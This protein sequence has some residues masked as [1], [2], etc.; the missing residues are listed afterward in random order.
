MSSA[1]LNWLVQRFVRNGRDKGN[2]FSATDA[3]E[4]LGKGMAEY[5]THV[6]TVCWISKPEGDEDFIMKGFKY[7]SEY[8]EASLMGGRARADAQYGDMAR[9]R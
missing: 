7:T 6:R 9:D 2:S 4:L 1:G 5:S 3:I 8:W